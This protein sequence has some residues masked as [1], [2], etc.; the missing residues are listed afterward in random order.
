MLVSDTILLL[1]DILD[2]NMGKID[3]IVAVV[4]QETREARKSGF[5]EYYEKIEAEKDRIGAKIVEMVCIEARSRAG[6]RRDVENRILQA[7]Q[8]NPTLVCYELSKSC[9]NSRISAKKHNWPKHQECLAKVTT[10]KECLQY[11]LAIFAKYR[12]SQAMG[13]P[14]DKYVYC[15]IIE[16]CCFDK[17]GVDIVRLQEIADCYSE[18]PLSS[19]FLD[20]VAEVNLNWEP[21]L[22][23]KSLYLLLTLAFALFVWGS[24]GV[25]EEELPKRSVSYLQVH[26]SFQA[27]SFIPLCC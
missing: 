25:F 1:A 21:C 11:C 18:I 14:H 8:S 3:G 5:R 27:L 15:R 13:T 10:V 26:S 17:F 12:S 2:K 16:D 6:S 19:E 20:F 22:D 9:I 24:A 4:K 23:S 7:F